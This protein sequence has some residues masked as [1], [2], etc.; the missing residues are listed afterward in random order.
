[1]PKLVSLRGM[2]IPVYIPGHPFV[3][4]WLGLWGSQNTSLNIL[5]GLIEAIFPALTYSQTGTPQVPVGRVTTQAGKMGSSQVH[6]FVLKM[7]F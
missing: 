6:G 5:S 3:Y 1:M 4:A 2:V 7:V